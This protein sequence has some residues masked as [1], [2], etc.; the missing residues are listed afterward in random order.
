[1]RDLI[2]I[3]EASNWA[4]NYLDK[5]VTSSNIFSEIEEIKPDSLNK[6]KCNNKL[7]HLS[8]V[9]LRCVGM[10]FSVRLR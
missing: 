4:S 7:S 8:L 3:K 2:T 1:M 6:A 5:K 10:K 9:P